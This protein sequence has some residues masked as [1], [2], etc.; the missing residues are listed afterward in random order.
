MKKAIKNKVFILSYAMIIFVVFF[1]FILNFVGVKATSDYSLSSKWDGAEVPTPLEEINYESNYVKM[2]EIYQFVKVG[3]IYQ[4]NIILM[5]TND[6]IYVIETA[7]DLY[8]FSLL[9]KGT[10]RNLFLG[11]HY[12]LG[13]DINYNDAA[14]RSQFFAPIG[15]DIPFTGI[16]DGQGFEISNLFF[17]QILSQSEYVNFYN[18]ALRYYS[19][20]SK[21]GENGIVRNLGI[22]NVWIDRK[23]VV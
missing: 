23:S 10:E 8:A 13:N 9:T 14:N 21:V 4:I 6:K 19:M 18:E 2:H 22:K 15:Y 7:E 11:L 1:A 3:S 5:P 17:A 12:V 20:F 16:F